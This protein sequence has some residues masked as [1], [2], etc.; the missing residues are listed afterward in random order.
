MPAVTL[1]AFVQT[2]RRH[3]ISETAYFCEFPRCEVI[4]FDDFERFLVSTDLLRSVWPKDSDAPL[5]GCFGLSA[6]DVA[7]DVR[8]GTVARVKAA[9]A[10]ANS[11]NT[12]CLTM[13]A[14]GRNC[15]ADIQ[16]YYFKLRSQ[17]GS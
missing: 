8:E 13:S 15:A 7:D 4:Y 9:V 6:D 12:H 14:K 1:A 3:E 11:A 2:E 10:K 5:C 16:R 17:F